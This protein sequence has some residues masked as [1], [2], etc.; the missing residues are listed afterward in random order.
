MNTVS[1]MNLRCFSLGLALLALGVA[2]RWMVFGSPTG[3]GQG[4]V[5]LEL[6]FAEKAALL[7]G[8]HVAAM[9]VLTAGILGARATVA[10]P[11]C[12][13]WTGVGALLE[14][15]QHPIILG[16]LQQWLTQQ[17]QDS[18]L[19][20][21]LSLYLLNG[22]F[23]HAELLAAIAGGWLGLTFIERLSGERRR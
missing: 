23:S 22:K 8:L 19:A 13:F 1:P 11:V 7:L 12:A 20:N 4:G 10:V 18:L 16:P 15:G 21:G 14:C 2:L 9:T 3:Q 5:A 6:L 17:P